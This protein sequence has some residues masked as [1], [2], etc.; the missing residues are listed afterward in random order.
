MN[1]L[2]TGGIVFIGCNF[3]KYMFA[4]YN[5]KIKIINLKIYILIIYTINKQWI[6]YW[7]CKKL[8][9]KNIEYKIMN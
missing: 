3:I 8:F 6:R 5:N 4:K 2:V 1:V 7:I 9:V